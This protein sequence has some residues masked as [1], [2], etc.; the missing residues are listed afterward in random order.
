MV[1][2]SGISATKPIFPNFLL[3]SIKLPFS[4]RQSGS[5][6]SAESAA[7]SA[8][9]T[10][11]S[12]PPSGGI[13]ARAEKGRL[14]RTAP[15]T[16]RC[17]TCSA[18]IA[19]ASQ[20][21]SKGFTGRYGRAFLVAPPALPAPQTLS[22]IRVGKSENRQLVTGWHIVA[23]INCGSCSTKLGWKYVD[24]KEQGQKYKVGKFILEVERVVTYRSWEDAIDEDVSEPTMVNRD[25]DEDEIVFDSDD[26][27]ECEDIFAGTW[28]AEVVEGR[29]RRMVAR[30]S[31]AENN[32]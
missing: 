24:A 7:S 20:I 31:Q 32:E 15:N 12:S 1:R 16:L 6:S 3:P 8:V 11:A 26:D 25:G 29:R 4:R 17:S 28:D 9:T 2:E 5:S 19:F 18:D 22:N 23:D 30:R 13:F 10:P 21:I 27:D 14:S